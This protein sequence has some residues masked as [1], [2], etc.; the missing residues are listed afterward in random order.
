MQFLFLFFFIC[1]CVCVGGG[2]V[3]RSEW[4]EEKQVRINNV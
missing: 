2:G 4:K 3:I 1:V